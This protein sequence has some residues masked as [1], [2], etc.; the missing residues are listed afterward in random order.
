MRK[1]LWILLFGLL[2]LALSSCV[3]VAD[4]TF[5]FESNWQRTS[6]GAY[7]FCSNRQSRIFYSFRGP[8]RSQIQEVT[9]TYTGIISKGVYQE[10]RSVDQLT[11]SGGRYT[12]EGILT[13]GPGG[14]PQSLP[15]GVSQQAIVVTPITPPPSN[16]GITTV[17]VTVTTTSGFSYS[18]AYVYDVY[19]NCP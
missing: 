14:I 9:E 18:G 12:F 19:S 15:A 7:V 17:T 5:K 10:Q 4:E 8:D 6:D 2:A 1:P 16:T 11:Y 13:F 3:I